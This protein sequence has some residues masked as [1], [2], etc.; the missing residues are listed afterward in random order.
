MADDNNQK[1]SKEQA[2]TSSGFLRPYRPSAYD[3]LDTKNMTVDEL[4]DQY[5]ATPKNKKNVYEF[6]A[7]DAD[8]Q[9]KVDNDAN[10]NEGQ[11]Q[12]SDNTQGGS[13]DGKIDTSAGNTNGDTNSGTNNEGEQNNENGGLGSK[14]KDVVQNAGEA[15]DAV[16][17]KINDIK[18]NATKTIDDAKNKIK[19]KIDEHNPLAE[20]KKWYSV[21]KKARQD[22]N[23]KKS[24]VPKWAAKAL[25]ASSSDPEAKKRLKDFSKKDKQIKSKALKGQAR[26]AAGGSLNKAK[27]TMEDIKEIREQMQDLSPKIQKDMTESMLEKIPQ[28]QGLKRIGCFK[29]IPAELFS[30]VIGDNAA[31]CLSCMPTS[32]KLIAGLLCIGGIV[33]MLVI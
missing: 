16:K 11:P 19:N 23:W 12:N 29:L 26:V 4:A 25:I 2:G 8:I 7:S 21:M 1:Y 13:A 28:F 22:D 27:E 6:D 5:E 33:G 24:N 32:M 18:E 9:R 30:K 17:D 31:S 10:A 15:V 3:L 14:I 20:R